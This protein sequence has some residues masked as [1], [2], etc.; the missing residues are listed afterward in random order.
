[1]SATGEFACGIKRGDKRQGRSFPEP[2]R[3]AI[4]LA[5]VREI[6]QPKG[7]HHFGLVSFINRPLLDSDYRIDILGFEARAMPDSQNAQD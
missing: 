1:M 3:G 4:D 7:W 6:S 5:R 2:I